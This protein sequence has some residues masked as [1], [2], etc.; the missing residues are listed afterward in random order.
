MPVQ[1]PFTPL[2]FPQPTNS[3]RLTVQTVLLPIYSNELSQWS[4]LSLLIQLSYKPTDALCDD[5]P[6]VLPPRPSEQVLTSSETEFDWPAYLRQGSEKFRLP[7]SSSDDDSVWELTDDDEAVVSEGVIPPAPPLPQVASVRRDSSPSSVVQRREV[8]TQRNLVDELKDLSRAE[9]WLRNN[10]QLGWWNDTGLRE[11]PPSRHPTANF[12]FIWEEA[13]CGDDARRVDRGD[14]RILSEYKVTREIVWLLSRPENCSIV[15]RAGAHFRAREDVSISSLSPPVFRQFLDT[16]VCPYLPMIESL[17]RFQSEM[18]NSDK[19]SRV[20]PNTYIS[21]STALGDILFEYTEKLAEIE[22]AISK[23]GMTAD[24]CRRY[25]GDVRVITIDV[26]SYFPDGVAT[27]MY[28]VNEIR[29]WL[30]NIEFVY[31]MH[32]EAVFTDWLAQENWL[33]AVRFVS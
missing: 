4:L 19:S 16:E 18:L 22:S 29:P 33:C 7:S 31:Q 23:Q 11:T 30:R 32:K 13:M 1:A 17:V 12:F 27:M 25:T 10:V 14:T 2:T 6:I 3:C 20:V 15:H 28:V 8:T 26:V 5:E 24:R 9:D 21:Y